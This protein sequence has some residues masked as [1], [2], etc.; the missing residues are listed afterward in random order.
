MMATLLPQFLFVLL[1]TAA[2][3]IVMRTISRAGLPFMSLLFRGEK[4]HA[5]GASETFFVQSVLAVMGF[6]LLLPALAGSP[7]GA[8]GGIEWVATLMGIVLVMLTMVWGVRMLNL[9]LIL[10]RRGIWARSE[11]DHRGESC[12]AYVLATACIS[13]IWAALFSGL[14]RGGGASLASS[15]IP[16]ASAVVAAYITVTLLGRPLILSVSGVGIFLTGIAYS[17]A[18]VALTVLF[19]MLLATRG[20]PAPFHMRSID[21]DRGNFMLLSSCV[22]G[23]VPFLSVVSMWGLRT[24]HER[25]T[26]RG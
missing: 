11:W 6:A 9:S 5:A 13:V 21:A 10:T 15:L 2:S 23:L 7:R 19:S 17:V 20:V 8:V 4:R 3:A 1:A 12:A 25:A 26:H 16:G 14:Y 22:L 24:V 18:V